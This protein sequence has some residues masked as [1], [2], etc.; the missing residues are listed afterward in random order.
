MGET[1]KDQSGEKMRNQK[2]DLES[3]SSGRRRTKNMWMRHEILQ[4]KNKNKIKKGG[5][6]SDLGGKVKLLL[7]LQ[8][9][10]ELYGHWP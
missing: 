3:N 8:E 9:N 4:D 1:G 7:L 2:K 5:G 10:S 6:E